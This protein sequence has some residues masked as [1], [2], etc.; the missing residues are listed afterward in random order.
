[1]T[2]PSKKIINYLII[3]IFG[4]FLVKTLGGSG[5]FVSK[6]HKGKGYSVRIPE[7]WKKVKEKKSVVYPLGVEVV[8]FVPSATDLDFQEMDVFIFIYSKKLTTPTW[9]EDEFPGILES[10]SK[11]GFKVMDKGEIKLDNVISKWVVYHDKKKPAVVLEFYQVTDNSM[12]YKIQYSTHPDKF[13]VFRP[14][15]EE[16]KDSFKFRFSLY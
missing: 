2:Q 15:F 7:G 5:F 9:I 3:F 16:L 11:A 12:F 4:V 8:T 14:D 13:N 6:V 1:M 10:L